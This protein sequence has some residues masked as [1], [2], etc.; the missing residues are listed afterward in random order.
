MGQEFQEA[1]YKIKE[2]MSNPPVRISPITR[3]SFNLILTMTDTA[4]GAMLTQKIEGEE[5]IDLLH[6]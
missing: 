1:F 3:H 4:M 6:N 5:M 2:Y